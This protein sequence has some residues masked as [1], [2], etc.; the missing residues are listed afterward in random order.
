[1]AFDSDFSKRTPKH[2]YAEVLLCLICGYLAG[3]V[4]IRRSLIW[5]KNNLETLRQYTPL[6]NGIASPSTVSRLL[7]RLDKVLFLAAFLEWIGQIVSTQGAHLAI[8]GKALRGSASKV[9]NK[10]APMTLNVV[11]TDT[12][13]VIAHIPIMQKTNEITA[14]SEVLEI[15]D[16]M[17]SIITIDAIGTQTNIMSLIVKYGGHFA[18]TVKKN[19][20]QTYDE[21]MMHMDHFAE[22]DLKCKKSQF[23]QPSYPECMK[24]YSESSWSEKN[25]DRYEYR[26]C[27]V[28]SEPSFLTRY[29][30]DWPFLKTVAQVMQVRILLVRDENGNDVTPDVRTFLQNGSRRQPMPETGDREQCDIQKIGMISDLELTAEELMTLKRDHWKIENSLHHVLDDTFREDRSPAKQSGHNL[31]LIRKIAY[32]ILR[33]AMI[34]GATGYKVMTEVMD[35]FCDDWTLMERFVFKGI[36]SLY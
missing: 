5:C 7:C 18:L 20:L 32:N 23:Y 24:S 29:N 12:G 13:L 15:I 26:S 10:R 16:I 28:C 4:T 35:A 3:R 31:A 33:L 19:Q 25:R 22:E 21:I 11:H 27:R 17:G 6:K 14:I 8:D 36:K 9:L 30:N 34:T 1:M 2:D